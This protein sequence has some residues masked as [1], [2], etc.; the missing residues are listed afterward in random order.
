MNFKE[1]TNTQKPLKIQTVILI[2]GDIY[3]SL[4]IKCLYSILSNLINLSL[5]LYFFFA[6]N[7]CFSTLYLV[8][9][10]LS[11]FFRGKQKFYFFLVKRH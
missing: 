1:A 9:N 11:V 6:I 7:F 4:H 2:K 8:F 5:F 10:F 3:F